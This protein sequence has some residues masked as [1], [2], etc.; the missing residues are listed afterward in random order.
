MSISAEYLASLNGKKVGRCKICKLG[1]SDPNFFNYIDQLRFG[2]NLSLADITNL[3]NGMFQRH[4]EQT[5]RDLPVLNAVNLHTHYKNHVP[6]ELISRP[7]LQVS[8]ATNEE[9]QASV[10]QAALVSEEVTEFNLF[11]QAAWVYQ[12]LRRRYGKLFVLPDLPKK[13]LYP[14]LDRMTKLLSL[15][16]RMRQPEEQIRVIVEA[17]MST[18][19]EKIMIAAIEQLERLKLTLARHI[20]DAQVRDK[21]V[22]D[23]RVALAKSFIGAAKNSLKKVRDEYPVIGSVKD[24]TSAV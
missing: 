7:Q 23:L 3:V 14:L 12:S 21:L 22:D 17:L 9:S 2:L 11:R 6:K 1:K 20:D 24:K 8:L 5:E 18:Y 13:R 4:G 15:L 16:D 19:G 10:E